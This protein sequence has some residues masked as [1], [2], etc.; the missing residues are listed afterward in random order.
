MQLCTL[1]ALTMY[2]IVLAADTAD[3]CNI[4]RTVT[5]IAMGVCTN[6][7]EFGLEMLSNIRKL[8]MLCKIMATVVLQRKGGTSQV[9][10][11]GFFRKAKEGE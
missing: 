5:R 1:Q 2:V 11:N 6:P 8:Q 4:I 10:L 9:G 3:S 7:P